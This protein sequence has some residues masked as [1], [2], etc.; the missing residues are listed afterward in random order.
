MGTKVWKFVRQFSVRNDTIYCVVWTKTRHGKTKLGEWTILHRRAYREGHQL[1]TAT[2]ETAATPTVGETERK[3]A[4]ASNSPWLHVIESRGTPRYN[5]TDLIHFCLDI[6]NTSREPTQLNSA[7]YRITSE[8]LEMPLNYRDCR[9]QP[10]HIALAWF[11]FPSLPLKPWLHVKMFS[12]SFEIISVFYLTYNHV[13]NWN[14][15]ISAAV[16]VL[17]LF[18]M[19]ENIYELQYLR[20]IILK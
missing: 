17:K 19:S 10:I 6:T 2:D 11:P 4:V 14:K 13:W 1:W 7:V 18:H 20:E 3:R 15:I 9:R 8:P 16:K 5:V 12:N